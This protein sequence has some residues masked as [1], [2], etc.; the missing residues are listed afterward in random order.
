DLTLGRVWVYDAAADPAY[1]L[2]MVGAI[3][4]GRSFPGN[5][6]NAHRVS[7][8]AVDVDD[9]SSSV[10]VAEALSSAQV[11]VSDRANVTN[12]VIDRGLSRSVLT[13]FRVLNAATAA[14]LHMPVAL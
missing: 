2:T 1:V 12:V 9:L 10:A 11:T 3:A 7:P 13:V 14:A 5:Q 6:V 8:Q 4:A